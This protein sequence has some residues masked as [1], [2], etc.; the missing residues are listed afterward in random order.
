MLQQTAE[1]TG[2][3]V[4]RAEVVKLIGNDNLTGVLATMRKFRT[5]RFKVSTGIA[6]GVIIRIDPEDE[7]EEPQSFV[8]D[9]PTA[10]VV[11][12]LEFVGVFPRQ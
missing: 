8:L 6:A 2:A 12:A 3:R 1:E 11:A 5:D 7:S 10:A 9:G 4:M